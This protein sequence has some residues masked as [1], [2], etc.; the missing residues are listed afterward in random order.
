MWGVVRYVSGEGFAF[1]FV[2]CCVMGNVVE[3]FECGGNW[4]CVGHR[5]GEV[6]GW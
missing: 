5:V 3:G 6:S 4:I 1:A 2:D